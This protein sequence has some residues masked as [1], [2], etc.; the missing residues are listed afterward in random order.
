MKKKLWRGECHKRVK[1]EEE[2]RAKQR[3]EAKTK[4]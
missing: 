4:L 2:E 3:N 1:A